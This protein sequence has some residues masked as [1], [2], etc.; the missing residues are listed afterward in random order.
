MNFTC[1]IYMNKF[2]GELDYC[3]VMYC[4][5]SIARKQCNKPCK[6]CSTV[7]RENASTNYVRTR[8][9]YFPHLFRRSGK[10]PC[11]FALNRRE[12]LQSLGSNGKHHGQLPCA[13]A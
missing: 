4:W 1:F 10:R 6:P 2:E 8:K 3:A 11:R 5:N 7:P 13:I 12:L 9:V